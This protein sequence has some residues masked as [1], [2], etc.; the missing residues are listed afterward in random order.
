MDELQRVRALLNAEAEGKYKLSVNDFV[1]KASSLALRKV[2]QCNSSWTDTH[3]RRYHNTDINVALNTDNGL[4]TPVIS[5]VEA[6]GLAD[7]NDRMKELSTKGRDGKLTPLELSTG[8]FTISNLGGFG[9]SQ[10][11]AVINPPQS[12]ILAVS[13]SAKKLIPSD[14]DEKGYEVAEIMTVTL[15]CDHRVVDGAIGAQW[16]KAFKA[17]L[18][19]PLRMLL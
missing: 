12:C 5:N 15:S 11:C 7:I 19:N 18:E 4:L 17:Y 16:L 13:A 3:V 14:A 2:P 1:I 10:F 9:I 8:T 6:L